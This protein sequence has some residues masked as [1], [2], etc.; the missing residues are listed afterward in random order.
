MAQTIIDQPRAN[1]QEEWHPIPGYQG[2]YSAS[3]IG[4]IRRDLAS[5]N[6]PAGHI[7]KPNLTRCG[8]LVIGLCAGGRKTYHTVHSLIALTFIGARPPGHQINHRDGI[9][10]HNQIENLEYVTPKENKAHAS[11]MGL[12]AR[13]ERCHKAKLTADDVREVRRLSGPEHSYSKLAAR[14][15]VTKGLI[16]MIKRRTIWTHI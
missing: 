1:H 11:G 8:Y 12:S 16:G 3:S 6:T 7:L 14:Y 10:L 5:S 13:G 9:K 4:R 15:G 2:I